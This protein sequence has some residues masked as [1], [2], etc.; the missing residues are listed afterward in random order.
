MA[1]SAVAEFERRREE[2]RLKVAA[3]AAASAR[4]TE[5]LKANSSSPQFVR[6]A[7]S[8]GGLSPLRQPALLSPAAS[9]ATSSASPGMSA[10]WAQELDA[11]RAAAAAAASAAAS[12]ELARLRGRCSAAEASLARSEAAAG[13]ALSGLD[14]LSSQVSQL[15]DGLAAS[16][17]A[18]RVLQEEAAQSQAQAQAQLSSVQRAWREDAALWDGERARLLRAQEVLQG[19]VARLTESTRG[20]L[21]RLMDDTAN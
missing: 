20:L 18:V 14:S 5:Q 7:S 15:A 6:G 8:V 3:L 13:A 10:A 19:E 1:D 17:E 16:Q 12:E 2:L 21:R 11:A 4:H 9:P